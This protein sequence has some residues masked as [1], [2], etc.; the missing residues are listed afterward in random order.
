MINL[1][2]RQA[3]GLKRLD[4][5]PATLPDDCIWVDLVE[6]KPDEERMIEQALAIDVPTREE[7]KEIEASSRLYEEHGALFMTATV[8]TRLDTDLPESAQ[9]TF[10]L[11]KNRLVTNRYVDPLPFRRF[12][13]YAERHPSTCTSAPVVLAGLVESIINRIADVLERAGTDLDALSSEIFAPPRKRRATPRNF[14]LVLDRIGQSGDFTSKARESLV[15]LGRLVAFVQQSPL[16]PLDRETK[17][18]F[19]SLSRDVLSLSDHSSFLGNKV[20]FLLEATLGMINI[21]QNNII[22]IFSVVTVFML[23]PSVIVGWFGMN[24]GHLPWLA[25]EHGPVIA[26][27]LMLLSAL[28]PFAIFKRLGWL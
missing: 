26:L 11:A 4:T 28:I 18:R 20:T 27:A 5:V 10:I 6:P 14:R 17:D 19:R 3:Q 8:A 15:S 9:V 25:L 21:D 23:P 13:A 1:F 12:I 24:F 16:I 2:V 22:K 7:M